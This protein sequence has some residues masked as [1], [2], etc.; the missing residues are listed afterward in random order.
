MLLVL[1]GMLICPDPE[2][3]ETEAYVVTAPLDE[4][5]MVAAFEFNGA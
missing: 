1:L 2:H 5:V 3:P 4:I